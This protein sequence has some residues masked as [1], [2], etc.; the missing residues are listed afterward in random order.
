MYNLS[1]SKL[2]FYSDISSVVDSQ[3]RACSEHGR[4]IVVGENNVQIT[5]KRRD[6]HMSGSL[7]KYIAFSSCID[8]NCLPSVNLADNVSEPIAID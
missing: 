8:H 5:D 6:I 2:S 3:I 1:D 4:L 7:A